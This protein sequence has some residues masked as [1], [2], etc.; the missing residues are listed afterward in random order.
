MIAEVKLK[1][2]AVRGDV[3]INAAILYHMGLHTLCDVVVCVTA[4]VVARIFRAMR[5]DE[6]PFR[7]VLAR[8]RAQKGI[9]ALSNPQF[10]DSLVDT[11][12][13]RNRGSMRSLERRVARLD[14][15]LRG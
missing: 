5:R 12:T 14:L 10:N 8:I 11:Y 4:P 15:R 6:L 9:C 2:A 13:V 1:T 7:T 3:L